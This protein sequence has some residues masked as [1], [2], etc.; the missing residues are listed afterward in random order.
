[1]AVKKCKLLDQFKSVPHQVLDKVKQLRQNLQILAYK[2]PP[3]LMQ[4]LTPTQ[5]KAK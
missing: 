3:D 5:A 4:E 2:D 1:M